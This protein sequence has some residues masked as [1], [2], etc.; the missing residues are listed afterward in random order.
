ME[1]QT[2]EIILNKLNYDCA[3]IVNEYVQDLLRIDLIATFK[4]VYPFELELWKTLN[5]NSATV[6]HSR[7][8]MKNPLTNVR[9]A[10]IRSFYQYRSPIGRHPYNIDKYLYVNNKQYRI[11][12]Q[13]VT[14]LNKRSQV[15]DLDCYGK[16]SL[17]NMCAANNVKARKSWTKNKIIT[18]LLKI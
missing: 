11:A 18:A 6:F 5:L 16:E 13:F 12:T 15:L 9:I 1:N 3:M 14:N 4:L 10:V 2:F 8:I 7:L 17:L